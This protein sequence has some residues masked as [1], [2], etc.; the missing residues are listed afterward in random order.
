M[1]LL[2]G[3]IIHEHVRTGRVL[4]HLA[5]STVRKLR[6]DLQRPGDV[7][8]PRRE[9]FP[10]DLHLTRMHRPSPDAAHQEGIL[11]L[12]RAGFRI[13]EVAERPVERFDLRRHAC[14]DETTERVVPEIAL[15]ERARRRSALRFRIRPRRRL[16]GGRPFWIR[17]RIRPFT[18]HS[19]SRMTTSDPEGLHAAVGGQVRW[20]ETH[21]G[22]TRARERDLAHALHALA[23]LEDR[24]KHDGAADPSSCFRDGDEPVH[25]ADVLGRRDLRHHEAG[26]LLAG[27]SNDL[28][29]VVERP[30]AVE[31]IDAVPELGSPGAGVDHRDELP[32]SSDLVIGVDGV[33]AVTEQDV[34]GCLTLPH[35]FAELLLTGIEEVEHPSRTPGHLAHRLRSARDERT[36]EV[37]RCGS[38]GVL[39][40]LAVP[41][42]LACS[43]NGNWYFGRTE[44][45]WKLVLSSTV[46]P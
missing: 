23:H 40:S 24:V 19:V 33:L 37:L 31:R 39:C 18:D 2:V 34:E 9:D 46:L 6:H 17:L 36:E 35:T 15:K 21:A 10:G 45:N 25:A 11:V 7:F 27:T 26:D 14:I 16:F 13:A 22:H 41:S 28:H 38:H 5:A 4:E 3:R 8:A 30:W 12:L 29:D 44:D 20:T 43:W 42:G 1:R 32:T